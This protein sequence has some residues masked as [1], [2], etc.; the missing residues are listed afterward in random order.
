MLPILLLIRDAAP[1]RDAGLKLLTGAKIQID[2]TTAN[3]RMV[4]GIFEV[5]R[6]L[7]NVEAELIRPRRQKLSLHPIHTTRNICSTQG[8]AYKT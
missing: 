6:Q 2:P 7:A 8:R 5:I 1:T 3:G 4:F